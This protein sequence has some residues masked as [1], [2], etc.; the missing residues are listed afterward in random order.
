MAEE[1]S[2]IKDMEKLRSYSTIFSGPSFKKLLE[3]E[4]YS[5]ID[6][7][8]KRFDKSKVNKRLVTYLDY[9]QFIYRE[10]Q[11]G[12]RCEYI[13]KNELLKWLIKEKATKNTIL[14]NEF[15]VGNSIAD[16]V[17]FNGTSRA[18]EIKTEYDT[19]RRLNSQ[20]N[21]YK[22]LFK[23]CYILV[24]QDLIEKFR[25]EDGAVGIIA[26]IEKPRSLGLE[27][28][29]EALPKDEIDYD[30]LMRSVRT[31][32]YKNI[33]SAYFG[34][35]P[36]VNSLNMFEAC[37]SQMK[38]IPSDIL[39]TLFISELKKRKSS[40]PL[41]KDFIKEL[42]QLCLSMHLSQE[43]CDLLKD[44]LNKPIILY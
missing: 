40:T 41:L 31:Q 32:E 22:R 2:S 24:H 13:Y 5:F 23:E 42:T 18:Y 9:I 33:I 30:V 29:R 10:L 4:D 21:D 25:Q 12:Y 3:Q 8:I 17:L 19:E 20:L 39:N 27:V 15:H 11:R 26:L 7:K 36:D 16:M 37:K 1:R 43:E 6:N 34:A 44:K 28:V 14:I 35:L 38:D